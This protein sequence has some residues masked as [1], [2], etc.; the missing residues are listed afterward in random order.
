MSF[1]TH[2]NHSIEG[3]SLIEAVGIIVGVRAV[4]NYKNE[5]I[6]DIRNLK[7]LFIILFKDFIFMLKYI[8]I[9]T[10]NGIKYILLIGGILLIILYFL[11]S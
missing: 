3:A 2:P 9:D 6:R 5:E 11:K 7:D 8:I 4:I 1:M 10:W